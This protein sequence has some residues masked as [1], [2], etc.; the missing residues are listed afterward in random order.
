MMMII[1]CTGCGKAGEFDIDLEFVANRDRCGSCSHQ[2]DRTWH[3]R[4]CVLACFC[5]WMKKSKMV[6]E[7]FPCQDC[8]NH[9]TGGPTGFA[10]GFKE[11]GV[12]KTCSGK[13]A[14]R[15]RLVAVDPFEG[16][17]PG[18]IGQS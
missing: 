13:G 12:C 1:H 17:P 15:G 5:E 3:Y 10:F 4:F 16:K 2:T 18:E 8:F 9:E 14:V 11:N 7:G 6:E